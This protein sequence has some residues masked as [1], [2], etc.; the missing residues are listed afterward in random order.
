MKAC[1]RDTAAAVTAVSTAVVLA[2]CGASAGDD[3]GEETRPS[4]GLLLPDTTPLAGRPPTS[5]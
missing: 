4:I 2:A 3:P 5:P 1:I